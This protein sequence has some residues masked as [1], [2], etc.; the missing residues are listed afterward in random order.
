M[1]NK[2]NAAPARVSLTAPL[3]NSHNWMEDTLKNLA[4][5]TTVYLDQKLSLLS[6]CRK[7]I[8]FD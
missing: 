3:N 1:V 6:P 7:A 8:Y 5:S 4:L 2:L